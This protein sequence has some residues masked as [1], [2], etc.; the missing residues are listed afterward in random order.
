MVGYQLFNRE[1]VDVAS[2]YSELGHEA[3]IDFL[4]E[5]L[6]YFLLGANLNLSCTLA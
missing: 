4:E 3:Y 1:I 2:I 5:N 6:K